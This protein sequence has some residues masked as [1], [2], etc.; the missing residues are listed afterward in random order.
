[1]SGLVSRSSRP[2]RHAGGPHD[3]EDGR[4]GVQLFRTVCPRTRHQHARVYS[5]ATSGVARSFLREVA[6]KLSP[7]LLE[8][9]DVKGR[10]VTADPLCGTAAI[11]AK[12]GDC[13]LALKATKGYAAR[14]GAE[15]LD[16]PGIGGNS[17]RINRL[18]RATGASRSA[19][20][21][22]VLPRRW[23]AAG[24]ATTARPLSHRQGVRRAAGRPATDLTRR[25]GA[26]PPTLVT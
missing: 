15:Y 10:T 9:V 1:M 6:G 8:L 2:L 23:L 14:G 4:Q 21:Q 19:P 18:A 24:A 3:A 12:S 26:R 16:N 20:L 7:E 22:S 5:R 25:F 13:A 11:V 17:C